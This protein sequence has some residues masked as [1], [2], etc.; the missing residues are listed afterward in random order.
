MKESKR[1]IFKK[2]IPF[3][4][5][6]LIAGALLL[7]AAHYSIAYLAWTN[8]EPIVNLFVRA[9][10]DIE[11]E[12][13]FGEIKENVAVKNVGNIDIYVR[14]VLRPE[15]QICSIPVEGEDAVCETAGITPEAIVID[16]VPNGWIK[17]GDKYY[18]TTPL[19]KGETTSLLVGS[20]GIVAPNKPTNA[21]EGYEYVYRVDVLSS[22]IQA[23]PET[24]VE[25]A[26]GVEVVNKEIV[27]EQ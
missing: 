26:W 10:P 17:L 19:P 22:S 12:E 8:E 9:R 18:Y 13:D 27:G 4:S 6:F 25:T 11:I 2:F 3:I 16:P 1:N 24:A 7:A 21:P 20:G 23:E 5:L 14:V 15:W